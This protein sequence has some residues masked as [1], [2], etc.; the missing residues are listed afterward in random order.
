L[1]FLH[2]NSSSHSGGHAHN[3]SPV[4]EETKQQA[5]IEA[6]REKERQEWL[7][8][9]MKKKQSQDE[10][11]EVEMTPRATAVLDTAQDHAV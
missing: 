4:S 5:D 6:R 8:Q 9:R 7:Q 10:A 3:A 2:P 1:R 11:P